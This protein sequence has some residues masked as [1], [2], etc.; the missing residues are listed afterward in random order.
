VGDLAETIAL[1]LP[2]GTGSDR[3]LAWWV[4]ERLLALRGRDEEEQRRAM[5]ECWRELSGPQLF[6]WNKL[7]TG[8]FRVGVSKRLV[9][10]ALAH[11]S[12][13]DA[14]TLAHR[15]MGDWRPSAEAWRRLM[16]AD[17]A[18]ADRS[19]PYPFFL[20]HPLEGYPAA[21]G[22][23]DEWLAEWKWDG[24][25]A[26]LIHRGGEIFIWTRGEELVSESYPELAEA[27]R[28][29]PEGTVLDGELLAWRD[30]RPLPFAALQRRIGRKTLGPR[31]LAEVPAVLVAYD[32]LEEAGEDVRA[33][34][35]AQRRRRLERLIGALA[36]EAAL[37]LSPPVAAGS[38]EELAALQAAAR[39]EGAEGLMLKRL[40]S[41]YG[42]GRP[43]GEWWKWKFDPYRVDAVLI[44][45]QR[46]HG[47]RASLY[48][49]YTFGVWDGDALVPFAKAYSGLTDAEIREVDRFVR[50]HTRERFG[51]VRAVE[52]R[53]VFE[54]AFEG[55]RR[56][57][58]H[59][60]GVA[61]RFPRMARWRRDK[62]P[63]EADRLES[64]RALL[65]DES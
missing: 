47:R 4:E 22:G 20:A 17:T 6:V 57:T 34:P 53:L 26:Q 7:I 1:L 15:L 40:T 61:V 23:L 9:L 25:R 37:L 65:P 35:L 19:R 44:Y 32:L 41:A 13:L 10:R 27:G 28:L 50:R 33:L 55:I 3:P 52:P 14:P 39:D 11:A 31:I 48:T 46:G 42:V 18:D 43:R 36:G 12:G 8:A 16:A 62:A 63:E 2:E 45:A 64:V 21:L 30:G 54:L 60:S 56:S 58:R 59:K 38:W 24:I 51:P 49:D 5:L 29:L